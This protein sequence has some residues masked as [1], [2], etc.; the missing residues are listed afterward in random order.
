MENESPVNFSSVL[1]DLMDSLGKLGQMQ[2]DLITN[3]IKSAVSAVE[4]LS[5][6]VFE[7]VGNVAT[8]LNQAVQNIS[9]SIAPKQ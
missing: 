8:S 4:P 5:K 7:T 1:N 2:V 6:S 9:S 3:G